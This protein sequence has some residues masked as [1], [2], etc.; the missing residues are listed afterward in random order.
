MCTRRDMTSARAMSCVVSSTTPPAR[1]V[2]GEIVDHVDAVLV[3]AG[4][5][6]VEQQ[7]PRRPQQQPGQAQAAPHAGGEA[8]H[9]L[10]PHVGQADVLEHRL[11]GAPSAGRPAMRS[12]KTRFSAAV[13]SSYSAL[14]WPSRP[15]DSRI[16]VRRPDRVVAEHRTPCPASG[17]AAC[18]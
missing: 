11:D 18:R 14:L 1:A 5:R 3:E 8:A 7:Q 10:P 15:T 13:R 12:E 9:P 6:L 2:L 16:A 4:I 17:A